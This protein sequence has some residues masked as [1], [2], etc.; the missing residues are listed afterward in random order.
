MLSCGW[1]VFLVFAVTL[2][3]VLSTWEVTSIDFG[4]IQSAPSGD[5]W[6]GTDGAGRDL[7]VRCLYGGQ[8]SLSIALIATAISMTVG[9][10]WGSVAGLSGGWVDNLMMRFVD[11]LYATPLVL[12]VI[13]LVVLFG[14]SIYL[15]FIGLGFLAWVDIAR[16]TRG[17]ARLVARQ[18]YITAARAVGLRATRIVLRHVIPNVFHV[19]FAYGLIA[20]PGVIIAE[21]F[22]SF[23]GLGVQ[24]PQTSW[25]VLIADGSR[26]IHSAPWHLLFPSVLLAITLAALYTA[27]DH[28]QRVLRVATHT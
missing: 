8:I 27:A 7:L 12:I 14:R 4:A 25:G 21:S 22:I 28:V 1:L 2:G 6:F 11:A 17:Q 18:E 9:L 23:L 24:E 20:I 10:L 19:A 5:H 16:I 3:P 15:I 13:L 26:V